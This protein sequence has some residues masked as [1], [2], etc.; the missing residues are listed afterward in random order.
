M[1]TYV[2][3]FTEP[4]FRYKVATNAFYVRKGTAIA[5]IILGKSFHSYTQEISGTKVEKKQGVS[6]IGAHT[7]FSERK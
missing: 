5:L 7:L 1:L 6:Q 3:N 2:M 4:H